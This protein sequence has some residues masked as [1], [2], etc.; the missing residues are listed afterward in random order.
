MYY[1]LNLHRETGIRQNGCVHGIV[2]SSKLFFIG[3]FLWRDSY[4]EADASGDTIAFIYD[5]QVDA[6]FGSPQSL[7]KSNATKHL[8]LN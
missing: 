2:T 8:G 5:E 7:R 6:I 3:R 1:F 4:L